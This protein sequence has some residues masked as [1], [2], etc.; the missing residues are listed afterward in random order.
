M[1]CKLGPR[2]RKT[3]DD[4]HDILL[5]DLLSR[6]GKETVESMHGCVKAGLGLK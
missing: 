4:Q 3:Q 2:L 6:P 1:S 5:L